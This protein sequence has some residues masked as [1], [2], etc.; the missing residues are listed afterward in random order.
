[1]LD[2]KMMSDAC[3]AMQR[4]IEK[5]QTVVPISVNLSRCDLEPHEGETELAIVDMVS[6]I[7]DEHGVPRSMVHIE[8]TESAMV[9]D[10]IDLARAIAR[11]HDEGFEVWLDDFGS[12][13]SSLT[14]SSKTMTST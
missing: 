1:M 8:I 9:D 4:R 5:G 6:S 2:L 10:T 11:F 12:G 13:E 3:K 7:V 14:M